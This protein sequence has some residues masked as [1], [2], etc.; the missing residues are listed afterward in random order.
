MRVIHTET[1]IH[2][3]KQIM[4]CFFTEMTNN[5]TILIGLTRI[6]RCTRMSNQRITKSNFFNI[7]TVDS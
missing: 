3:P 7:V 5:V 4:I 2:N 1:E 6:F